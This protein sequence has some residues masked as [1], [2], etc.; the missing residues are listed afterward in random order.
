[1][2]KYVKPELFYERYELSQHVAACT[3]DLD[4]TNGTDKNACGYLTRGLPWRIIDG[5]NGGC[6]QK[7]IE[8]YCYMPPN[9]ERTTFVS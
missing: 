5:N 4:V 7:D 6:E 1:M 8:D 3:Y 2:K 9:G